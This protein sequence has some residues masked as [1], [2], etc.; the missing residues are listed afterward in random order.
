MWDSRPPLDP[1]K[2]QPHP[3]NESPSRLEKPTTNPRADKKSV[4]CPPR[5][6]AGAYESQSGTIGVDL[7]CGW[8]RHK[9]PGRV[10]DS[11]SIS[12]VQ[13]RT[14]VSGWSDVGTRT[15]VGGGVGRSYKVS[16][17]TQ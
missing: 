17:E 7:S 5:P 12:F 3:S 14:R 1:M 15:Y 13:T 8:S 9:V 11:G 4:S 16:K 6:E 2:P 10:R